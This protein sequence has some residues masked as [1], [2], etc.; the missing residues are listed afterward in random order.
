MSTFNIDNM[1]RVDQRRQARIVARGRMRSYLSY[2]FFHYYFQNLLGWF[3][4][5]RRTPSMYVQLVRVYPERKRMLIRLPPQS[6]D[7]N[8]LRIR[9]RSS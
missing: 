7:N 4:D 9:R 8:I 6:P 1:V 5:R 2:I 3:D